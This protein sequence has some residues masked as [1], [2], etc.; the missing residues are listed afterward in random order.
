MIL[1][2]LTTLSEW[3]S[4]SQIGRIGMSSGKNVTVFDRMNAYFQKIHDELNAEMAMDPRFKPVQ[5]SSESKTFS[6]HYDWVQEEQRYIDRVNNGKR[7][8]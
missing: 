8:T 5:T 4:E 3:K 6:G 2:R 1:Y 7:I